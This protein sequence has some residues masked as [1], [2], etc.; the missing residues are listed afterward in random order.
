MS[1]IN[2]YEHLLTL[3]EK[4]SGIEVRITDSGPGI[5]EEEQAH[6]FERYFKAKKV[7][8]KSSGAGLGLAIVKKILEIHNAT[9]QVS[10]KPDQG[11]SFYFQLPAYQGV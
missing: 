1:T 10:S 9:I 2:N 4:E 6:I 3:N 8:S 7:E 11:A 5:T